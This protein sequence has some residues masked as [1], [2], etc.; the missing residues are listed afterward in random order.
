MSFFGTVVAD[1]EKFGEAV[2]G[3][4]ET[5]AADAGKA[6]AFLTEHQS[7]ILGLASLAGAATGKIASNA[8]S[9]YDTVA[10]SLQAAGVAAGSNGINVTLDQQ[11]I[12]M[13]LAD[14]QAVKNF[15]K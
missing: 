10:A 5:V 6:A 3:G 12:N 11:T 15:G 7:T 8:L 14:I 9:L 1:L 4:I 13:I 2:K